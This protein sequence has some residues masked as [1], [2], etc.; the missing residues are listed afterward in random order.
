MD[1][2]GEGPRLRR[3]FLCSVGEA[4]RVQENATRCTEKVSP[5]R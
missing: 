1:L 3:K 4:M 2:A 5:I